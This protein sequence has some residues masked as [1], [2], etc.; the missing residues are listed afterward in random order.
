MMIVLSFSYN[1]HG[2]QL[3]MYYVHGDL[4][5]LGI[6]NRDCKLECCIMFMIIL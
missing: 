5:V 4:Y 6:M 3:R 2:L 1:E